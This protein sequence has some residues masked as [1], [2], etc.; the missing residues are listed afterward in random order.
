MGGKKLDK[1][2]LIVDDS[3]FIRTL[4]KRFVTA[5]GL[6]KIVEA[7]DGEEAIEKCTLHAPS[8]IFLDINMPRCDGLKTLRMLKRKL[9]HSKVV[10]VSA[11]GQEAVVKEAIQNG[12]VGYVTKPFSREDIIKIVRRLTSDDSPQPADKSS[13]RG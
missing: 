6:T 3:R 13:D 8:L 1:T 5:S 4:I 2:V 11:I 9:P 10:I 7:E 12:A